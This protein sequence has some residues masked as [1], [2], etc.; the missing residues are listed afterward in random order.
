MK[1]REFI[2]LLG[3]AAAWPF[4]AR[5]Q[6]PGERMRRVGVLMSTG[7]DDPE[8]QARIAAFLGELHRLGWTDGPMRD[9]QSLLARRVRREL[10]RRSAPHGTRQIRAAAHNCNHQSTTWGGR[11]CALESDA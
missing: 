8:G 7:A 5:R 6:Q 4:A 1:R 11:F 3:G 2:T 9:R 10:Q